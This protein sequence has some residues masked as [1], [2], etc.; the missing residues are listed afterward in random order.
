MS[1][2]LVSLALRGDSG[3]GEQTRRHI[4]EV[5]QEIGY[6][7]NAWARSLVQGRTGLIGV[8][9]T[10]LAN[11]YSTG[12]ANG[13]EDAAHDRGF[14]VLIGHG[15]R[16]PGIL[17]RRI[18]RFADLGAEGII[19][20]SGH[21][22]AAFLESMGQ[23]V[24]LVVVGRYENV[25]VDTVSNHDEAG[26]RLAMEHLI[27]IGHRSIVHVPMSTRPST[28]A[29]TR[30]AIDVAAEHE[31]KLTV[32]G[33]GAV[34]DVLASR[35]ASAVFASNDLGALRVMGEL[36]DRGAHI[37]AD[38][39]VIGYDDSSL[40]TV[41]RPGLS[42]V[43][44]PLGEM[45]ELALAMLRERMGGRTEIRTEVLDPSLVVRGSTVSQ[46]VEE[47]SVTLTG[48]PQ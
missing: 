13:I 27:D 43:R 48:V 14:D 37:P 20:V 15:R 17:A 46:P 12:V 34:H 38:M 7:P 1:K 22:D 11:P 8:V 4:L 21:L 3:V 29:R 33:T 16:D 31:V 47:G 10:D 19:V 18:T 30:T 39:A 6:R 42:S 44:Q 24:P 32:T 25:A 45:G 35:D 26:A 5:A 41:S 40:A 23:R 2:S 28:A 9:L 36:K